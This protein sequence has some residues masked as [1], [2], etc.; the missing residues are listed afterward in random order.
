MKGEAEVHQANAVTSWT[1]CCSEILL[2]GTESRTISRDLGLVQHDA[3]DRESG[4]PRLDSLFREAQRHA[5][6]ELIGYMN[7][8]AVIVEGL[9][10]AVREVSERLPRFLMVCR[11]WDIDLDERLDFD[12]DWRAFVKRR[13]AEKNELHSDCSSDLFLFKRPLWDVLPFTP[14]SP[15]W[16][17]WMLWR[18]CDTHTPVV[19]VTPSVIMA[20]PNHGYGI[21]GTA[22]VKTWWRTSPLVERNRTLG[23]SGKQF[24]FRHV[25]RAH[26]LWKLDGGLHRVS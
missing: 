16:D 25:Q 13:I 8:D 24:C 12:D 10:E 11:R 4:I 3:V 1:K 20:H 9:K 18:A 23:G 21:D 19:D 7:A 17:N 2:F 6:N 22:D 15:E 14:G 26:N 5:T